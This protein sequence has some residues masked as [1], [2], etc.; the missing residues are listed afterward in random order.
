VFL[1]VWNGEK[2]CSVVIFCLIFSGVLTSLTFKM[3]GENI[4]STY[5]I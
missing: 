2:K 5:P 4:Y 3:F 1:N